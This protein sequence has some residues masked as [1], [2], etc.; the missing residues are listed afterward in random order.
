MSLF[1]DHWIEHEKEME[2]S[3]LEFLYPDFKARVLRVY[4]DIFNLYRLKMRP[5]EGVRLFSTQA[6]YY[7]KGRTEPGP[8]ITDAPPGLSNHH[9]G[10]A[11]DSCFQG[12]D[13]YLTKTPM[14]QYYWTQYAKL[15]EA[16]GLKA[17][18]FFPHGLVD[19]PHVELMY[20]GLTI[21]DIY[22]LYQIHGLKS[23]WTKFDQ[24]RHVPIGQEWSQMHL[25]EPKDI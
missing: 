8:I 21:H 1:F 7:A 11:V 22:G 25:L 5:T 15:A 14:G 23:V 24:I 17:G 13:P 10:I 16:H 3:A 18:L 4:S 20:G 12:M 19:G 2:E 9:Y 6:G